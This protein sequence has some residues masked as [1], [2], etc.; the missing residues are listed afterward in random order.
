MGQTNKR[1]R[2]LIVAIVS[3]LP[4]GVLYSVTLSQ[5]LFPGSQKTFWMHCISIVLLLAT[6]SICEIASTALSKRCAAH[7]ITIV[8]NRVKQIFGICFFIFTISSGTWRGMELFWL[9]FTFLVYFIAPPVINCLL[10]VKTKMDE[11]KSCYKDM[12]RDSGNAM[13]AD[14]Q[15]S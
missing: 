6:I 7:K 8:F 11:Q 10:V 12:E 1:L 4:I 2:K 13:Q 15:R 3:L 14:S 5:F 9:I